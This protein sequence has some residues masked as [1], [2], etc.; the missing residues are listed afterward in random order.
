L[1]LDT[2]GFGFRHLRKGEKLLWATVRHIVFLILI[3][4]R[5][6][7]ILESV[8]GIKS[9]QIGVRLMVHR[10]CGERFSGTIRIC[11]VTRRKGNDTICG[12]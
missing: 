3:L 6:A 9:G 12:Y 8:I 11:A 10:G 2:F 7:W 5:K 1:G 4:S